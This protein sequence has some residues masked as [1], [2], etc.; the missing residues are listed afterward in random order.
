MVSVGTD[1]NVLLT[2]QFFKQFFEYSG[3]GG[4]P[5]FVEGGCGVDGYLIFDSG[6]CVVVEY[7]SLLLDGVEVL[8]F[9]V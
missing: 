7:F 8:A 3:E 2:S 6:E 4:V 9:G 5:G 1:G